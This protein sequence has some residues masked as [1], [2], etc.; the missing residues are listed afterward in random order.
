VRNLYDDENEEDKEK[1]EGKDEK[2]G[3][4]MGGRR[5]IRRVAGT[6]SGR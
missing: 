2:G 4:V 5:R 3:E 6:D 1:E